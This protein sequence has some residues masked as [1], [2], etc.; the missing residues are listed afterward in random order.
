MKGNKIITMYITFPVGN[1]GFTHTFK[2]F[3]TQTVEKKQKASRENWERGRVS[4]RLY[5]DTHGWADLFK[6]LLWVEI[7]N[8]GINALYWYKYYLIEWTFDNPS[9]FFS[10]NWYST[11]NF[12]FNTVNILKNWIFIPVNF[13]IMLCLKLNCGK[14]INYS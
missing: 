13:L 5:R 14:T 7:R 10:Y 2:S 4:S 9:L 8:F 6:P 3:G 1:S 12:A 11:H